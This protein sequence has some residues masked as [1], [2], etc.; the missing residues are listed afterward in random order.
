MTTFRTFI[1]RPG[2]TYNAD[3]TEVLFAEDLNQIAEAINTL[4]ESEGGVGGT[5]WH[6]GLGAPSTLYNDGDLYLNTSNGDVYKQVSAAWGSPILNIKGANGTDGTNGTSY[7][8]KGAKVYKSTGQSI[9]TTLTALSFDTESFDTNTYHDTST[10]NTRLTVSE[11]G[12]YKIYGIVSTT[13]NAVTRAQIRLNGST[14]L[15]GVGAGN[16]GASID[17]GV[18]VETIHYLNSG[19][20]VELLGYFG[21][22]VTSTSGLSGCQFGIQSLF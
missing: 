10:N 16:A 12:Y 3:K 17:N 9:G 15:A 19:D 1:N 22:T 4:E 5:I 14:V 13:S 7:S 21:S 6:T 8:F 20:Y 18:Y 2:I 11:T